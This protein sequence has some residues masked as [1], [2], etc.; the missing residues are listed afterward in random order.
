MET[1]I[2]LAAAS[3]D[4]D[5]DADADASV[6]A[7]ADADASAVRTRGGEGDIRPLGPRVDWPPKAECWDP[8]DLRLPVTKF[9]R[10]YWDDW[11]YGFVV[12]EEFTRTT[13]W[14]NKIQI[15]RPTEKEIDDGIKLIL[16]QTQTPGGI[17]N[18]M[19]AEIIAQRSQATRYWRAMLMFNS[20]SHPWTYALMQVS[21]H[22][23]RYLAMYYKAKFQVPRPSQVSPAILP[24]IDPPPHAS[25]P[26]GH[27]LEG[28]LISLVLAE[29]V[30]EARRP[31]LSLAKRVG[32][33][34]E[35]A[36]LHY[37]FDTDAGFKVAEQALP[38]LMT[39][40]SY[41]E[42]VAGAKAEWKAL[43]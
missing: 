30:P 23:A 17:R 43:R 41:T 42:I 21:H 36:G 22:V 19:M 8:N 3:A 12:I 25:Y 26:S 32:R 35:R 14:Q 27:A 15:G 39:C 13:D 10:H 40:E 16:R 9:P 24:W 5:A 34:R 37:H 4:A 28:M 11:R 2:R 1:T 18:G 7:D 33:N 6:D 38:L 31:L 29:V 20:R